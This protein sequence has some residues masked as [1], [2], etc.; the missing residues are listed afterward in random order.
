MNKINILKRVYFATCTTTLGLL[1]L[2]AS[3]YSKIIGGLFSIAVCLLGIVGELYQEYTKHGKEYLRRACIE[4]SVAGIFFFIGSLIIRWFFQKDT[5]TSFFNI[6]NLIA[7]LETAAIFT[8][9]YY[10]WKRYNMSRKQ[11][12]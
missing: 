8:L 10:L 12:A 3:K 1:L 4:L 5:I 2:T 9:F 7:S 11:Q 6:D